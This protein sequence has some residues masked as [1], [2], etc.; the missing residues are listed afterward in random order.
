MKWNHSTGAVHRLPVSW[1][2]PGNRANGSRQWAW[3]AERANKLGQSFE[4]EAAR[5]G[6][7]S[8]ATKVEE[9]YT[10][11]VPQSGLPF[12]IDSPDIATD[13]QIGTLSFHFRDWS[14]NN[15]Y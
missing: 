7:Q 6:A 1:T 10:S 12:V 15:I 5:E 8:M 2:E 13:Q 14:A 4:P 11:Y 3:T 9:P